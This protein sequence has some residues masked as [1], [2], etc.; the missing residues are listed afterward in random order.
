MSPRERVAEAWAKAY[1]EIGAV[2]PQD[3]KLTWPR[4]Q[5]W[6]PGLANR[7]EAAEKEAEAVSVRWLNGGAG[8]VQAAVNI[9]RDTWLEA[10]EA[11]RNGSN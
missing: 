6:A 7:I 5:N 9:W 8:G 3:G 2:Y 4:L 1:A 10:I 11:I